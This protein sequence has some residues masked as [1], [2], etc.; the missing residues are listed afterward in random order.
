MKKCETKK[1]INCKEVKL[2]KL[3][4]HKKSSNS[5]GYS[6][7]C[8]SCTAKKNKAR[9]TKMQE[10]VMNYAIEQGCI[11]CGERNPILLEFDHIAG[12]GDKH[13]N[14]SK[15]SQYSLERVKEEIEKCVV[16]CVCCHRLKTALDFNWYEGIKDKDLYIKNYM[17]RQRI[18]RKLNG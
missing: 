8:K 3:F 1:C 13:Y 17:Q 9:R 18:N 5:C 16:R 15:M 6:N 11:D 2:L 14:I 4:F 7:I 12:L 10:Y